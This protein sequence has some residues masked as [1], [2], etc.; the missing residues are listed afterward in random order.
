MNTTGKKDTT[1]TKWAL[2]TGASSGIGWAYAEEMASRGYAVA[3]VSNEAEA[4]REKAGQLAARYGVRTLPLYRDL[5]VAGAA[6]ELYDTCCREGL[7]IEV[8]INNAGMFFFRETVEEKETIVE[9]MLYLHLITPTQLMYY[10]GGEMKKRRHGY[11][12]TMSSL[13]AWLPYPGIALYASTKRY[14]KSFSRGFRS[15]LADYGVSV[16]TVCPGAVCTN[17][18]PLSDRLKKLAIRLGI[19]M[20]PEKLAKKAVSAMFRGR[21][22]LIPG[23]INRIFLPFLLP[24]PAGGV[25]WAMRRSKLLPPTA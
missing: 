15:E 2:I 14:L 16:T 19:M 13:S 4:I 10:F 8:L 20:R 5:A 18:Y 25:R 11:M 24:L 1:Q 12:L 7:E 17:L 21:S 6:R 3:M 22:S 9:K 23:A